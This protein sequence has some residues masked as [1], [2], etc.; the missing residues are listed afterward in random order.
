M[1]K[2]NVFRIKPDNDLLT[3]I[4]EFCEKNNITSGI[5][6]GIIGSLTNAKLGFLKTL[7]ANYIS[8]EFDGPLEIVCAQGNIS[9]LEDELVIHIH[10]LISNDDNA[11]GGHLVEANVFSTAEVVIQ[12]LDYQI[13]RKLDDYTGLNEIT[14]IV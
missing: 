11:V 1:P 6:V 4:K 12:E 9:L 13:Q 7:P 10:L 2:I 8:K 3:S 14:K 5:I